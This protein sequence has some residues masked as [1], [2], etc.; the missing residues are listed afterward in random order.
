[1]NAVE[2]VRKLTK[3]VG[4]KVRLVAIVSAKETVTDK[5]RLGSFES[6]LLCRLGVA[7]WV[8]DTKYWV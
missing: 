6:L 4:T 2:V 1:M 5:V 8:A 3:L 7:G